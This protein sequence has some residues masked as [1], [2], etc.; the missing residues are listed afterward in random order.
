MEPYFI[1]RPWNV[2]H[3][4]AASSGYFPSNFTL[5]DLLTR[6]EVVHARILDALPRIPTLH[7]LNTSNALL[8]SKNDRYI[9]SPARLSY[10]RH[11]LEVRDNRAQ[12]PYTKWTL[13]V[14][15]SSY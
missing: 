2:L 13:S 12:E 9:S 14:L 7:R 10:V 1:T 11:E 3:L 6:K 15:T 5:N 4:L 8:K